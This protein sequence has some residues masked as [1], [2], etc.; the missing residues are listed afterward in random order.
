MRVILFLLL[1]LA[2]ALPAAA[3]PY[4]VGATLPAGTNWDVDGLEDEEHTAPVLL[5][6]LKP[7]RLA[8]ASTNGAATIYLYRVDNLGKITHR[9]GPVKPRDYHGAR[10]LLANIRGRIDAIQIDAITG[11]CTI[12]V[13]D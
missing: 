7:A 5:R 11:D 8:E 12:T 9:F 13:G 4:A 10:N 1:I 6:L 2:V 3:V